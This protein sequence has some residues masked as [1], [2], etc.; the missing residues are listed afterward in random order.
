M[1]IGI[2]VKPR[3]FAEFAAARH[4]TARALRLEAEEWYRQF[5]PM[6]TTTNVNI[7]IVGETGVGKSSFINTCLGEDKAAT[8]EG[9]TTR[10]PTP[11]PDKNNTSLVLWDLPGANSSRFAAETYFEGKR[12][13]AARWGL[14]EEYSSHP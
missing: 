10:V 2:A 13:D 14:A 8:G 11:Y 5:G 4:M 12:A 6:D 7:G 3:S 1:S 9:E